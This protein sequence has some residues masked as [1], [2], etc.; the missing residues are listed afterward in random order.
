ML[1]AEKGLFYVWQFYT[2]PME[3]TEHKSRAKTWHIKKEETEKNIIEK[4]QTKMV[5]GNR[6]KKK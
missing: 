6:R 5:D 4:H 3:T 2:N 1:S